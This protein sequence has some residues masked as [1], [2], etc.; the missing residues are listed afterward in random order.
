[1]Q[2]FNVDPV[3]V[4]EERENH[5]ASPVEP[6]EHQPRQGKSKTFYIVAGVV[7]LALVVIAGVGIYY[8][9]KDDEKAEGTDHI[10]GAG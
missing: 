6:V 7:I 8:A 1:M 2:S 9:T 3:H 4:H 5:H 10:S